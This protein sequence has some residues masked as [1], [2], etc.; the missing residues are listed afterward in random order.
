MLDNC[1]GAANIRT[2]TLAVKKCPRCGAEVEVFSNDV[3]VNCSACG[4][5]VYND[6][7]SCVQWCTYARECVGEETYRM[8]TA[9]RP[10]Q[11]QPGD[12]HQ[13]DGIV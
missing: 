9:K 1:P 3:S 12:D 6:I 13:G 5:T 10:E 8:L 7:L 2:P 4:F 11:P